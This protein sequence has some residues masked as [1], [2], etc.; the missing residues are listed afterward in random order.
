MHC[1]ERS[2]NRKPEKGQNGWGRKVDA[3]KKTWGIEFCREAETSGIFGSAL[4]TLRLH[5]YAQGGHSPGPIVLPCRRD[6]RL[7]TPSN[8]ALPA[9]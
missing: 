3:R 4:A 9:C 6:S 2:A 1:E 7:H 5:L 8:P